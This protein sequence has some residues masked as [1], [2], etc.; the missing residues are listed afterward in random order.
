M[1]DV[2]KFDEGEEYSEKFYDIKSDSMSD[3]DKLI[4]EAI[5]AANNFDGFEN[6]YSELIAFV[7]GYIIGVQNVTNLNIINN[8]ANTV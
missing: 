8:R 6:N 4:E 1:I 2:R 5:E 7:N 3:D